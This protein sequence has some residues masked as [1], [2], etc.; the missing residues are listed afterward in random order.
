LIVIR[1]SNCGLKLEEVE[2]LEIAVNMFKKYDRCPS[3]RHMFNGKPKRIL[4]SPRESP[5]LLIVKHS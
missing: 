3:C 2:D 1:C 4:I 5:R